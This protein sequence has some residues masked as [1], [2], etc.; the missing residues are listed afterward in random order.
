[1]TEDGTQVRAPGDI[2]EAVQAIFESEEDGETRNEAPQ[3]L[4]LLQTPSNYKMDLLHAI[5]SCV[6]DK[7]FDFPVFCADGVVWSNKLL[8][9]AASKVVRTALLDVADPSEA[10]LIVPEVNKMEFTSFHNAMFAEE[11]DSSL[12]FLTLIKVAEVLGA[13]LVS[14]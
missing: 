5:R 8:L 1:M 2:S 3:Q 11:E 9:T 10:C 4:Y 12:D 7:L 14:Y 6:S 13:E